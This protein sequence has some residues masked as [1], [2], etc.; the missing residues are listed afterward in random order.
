MRPWLCLTHPDDIKYVFTADTGVLRL[1]AAL[2]KTSPHPLVLG[3]TWLTNVDGAEHPRRRRMQLPPFRGGALAN[4]QSIMERKTED[5]LAR[6]P[7]GRATRAHPHLQV[8]S[9]E[10]II[11]VV[12]GVTDPDRVE[13]LRAATQ[14]L[15]REVNSRRFL[16]R[17]PRHRPRQGLGRALPADPRRDGRGRC[18]RAR[19][20]RR[21]SPERRPRPRRCPRDVPARPRRDI[22]QRCPTASSA[23]RCAHCCSAVMRPRPPRSLGSRAGHPPPRCARAPRGRGDRGRRRYIDAVSRR[24]CGCARCSRFARLAAEAFELRGLTIPAGT[25]IIPFITLVH[26]RPDLY[27][28]PL[29]FRPQRFLD[30]RAGTYTWIPFGGGA[31]R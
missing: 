18:D 12:F 15:I 13:R 5:A 20:G 31:R 4:Y 28:D 14:G 1:G 22:A 8:I 29:A 3:P 30:A 25:L 23:R 16:C 9:L 26:R 10:V 27:P 24:R 7:Y 2:A 6:W 21:A 19:R 17:R 11:A